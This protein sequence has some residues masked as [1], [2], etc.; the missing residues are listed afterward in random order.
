MLRYMGENA[1]DEKFR[2]ASTENISRY[3]HLLTDFLVD[4]ID[5]EPEAVP[6]AFISDEST[7]WYII[8]YGQ[9]PEAQKA[10]ITLWQARIK[11]KYGVDVSDLED[12]YLADILERIAASD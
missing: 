3:E 6:F 12:A 11:D 1:N 7:L 4:I 10:Q 8:G 5:F 9:D 2:R